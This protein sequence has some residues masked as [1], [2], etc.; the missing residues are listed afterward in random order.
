MAAGGVS[1]GGPLGAYVPGTSLL[2]RCPP[3]PKL[4]GLLVA[5]TLAIRWPEYVAVPAVALFALARVPPRMALA[6]LRPLW[7][8]L[9]V[10][11]G[12]QV[13]A[14]GLGPA[15]EVIGGIL[16]AVALASLV[17]LTTRVSAMLD[18]LVVAARPLRRLGID[19]DRVALLFAL[20]IRSIPL[21]TEIVRNVREAQCARGAGNNPIALAIP[22]MIRTLRA[23]DA[24][25]E[26]LIARGIDD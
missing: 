24:L 2:H 25:G 6:Q 8:F 12:F 10:A 23:A 1:P 19:P 17:T 9:A 15:I 16:L 18:A 4:L 11:F 26:A 20:A 3:G 21:I 14:A 22:T 5:L 7:L 13:L